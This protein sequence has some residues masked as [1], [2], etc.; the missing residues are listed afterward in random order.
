MNKILIFSILICLILFVIGVFIYRKYKVVS[1][2]NATSQYTIN[3]TT[4]NKCSYII[5][6]NI[7]TW[8]N[9]KKILFKKTTGGMD[10]FIVFIGDLT[11]ILYIYS[12]QNNNNPYIT[13][14]QDSENMTYNPII[15]PYNGCI[16]G[17]TGN[18]ISAIPGITITDKT[19]YNSCKTQCIN[20]INCSGFIFNNN[21]CYS[22][23]SPNNIFTSRPSDSLYC[24]SLLSELKLIEIKK[25]IPLQKLVKLAI[26]FNNE[27]MIVY[28]DDEIISSYYLAPTITSPAIITVTPD[29]FGFTGYTYFK[30]I[31]KCLNY[32]EIKVLY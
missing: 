18:A 21:T 17:I 11:N 1:Y 31:N 25:P 2:N 28:M 9:G 24:S 13:D 23:N 19:D 16:T 4:N 27:N 29:P 6:F 3:I 12:Q 26:T 10:D 5:W 20:N 15:L 14:I 32:Q 30:Y 22:I 8:N 7:E